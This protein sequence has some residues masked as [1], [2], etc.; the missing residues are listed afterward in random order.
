MPDLASFAL[1]DWLVGRGPKCL[2]KSEAFWRITP[3]WA[4]WFSTRP[5][6]DLMLKLLE[7]NVVRTLSSW[8]DP[9]SSAGEMSVA[10]VMC[11]IGNTAG[12]SPPLPAQG[13]KNVRIVTGFPL[14]DHAE[15]VTWKGRHLR[16]FIWLTPAT[17][18]LVQQSS[19]PVGCL[20]SL[21]RRRSRPEPLS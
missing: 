14:R 7:T 15:A 17:I 4:T 12:H 2:Q 19:L 1:L 20:F 3:H 6:L 10:F 5:R 18:P 8:G 9:S 11:M 21:Q 13:V 16:A